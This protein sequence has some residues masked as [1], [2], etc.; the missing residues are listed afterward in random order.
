LN[1]S[2]WTFSF[3][4]F[5]VRTRSR[6]V[7]KHG[8]KLKLRPQP[9]QILEELLSRSGEL[10]T[11]EELREKLWSSETF[12][13]F[14]QS[15]NTSVKELRA[16]LGDSATEPRYVETVPR[17][18]Y[19]FIAAA[20][21]IEPA[22][23]NGN[24]LLSATSADSVLAEGRHIRRAIQ[25][26]VWLAVLVAATGIVV[27]A[28][29]TLRKDLGHSER[30]ASARSPDPKAV[31]AYLRG[32][33]LIDAHTT[34]D[35]GRGLAYFQ[36]AIR[37]DPEFAP[38]YAASA[39]MYWLLTSYG[40]EPI[41]AL[42]LMKSASDKALELD[43]NLADAHAVRGLVLV[44]LQNNWQAGETEFHRALEL[45][46]GESA[47]HAYYVTGFLLPLGRFDAAIAEM[48][49]TLELD[50]LSVAFNSDL[51]FVQYFARRYGEAEAQFHKALQME[52]SL[53]SANWALMQL[54][55]QQERWPE[56]FGQFQK[57]L[58][59]VENKP[60]S[61]GKSVRR[62]QFSRQEYW[63]NRI[64]MQEEIVKDLSDY[65]DLAVVYARSGQKKKAL[66]AL[67]MA[68]A[69]NDTYL[70]LINVEPAL[71]PLRDEPRFRELVKK[72][73]FPQD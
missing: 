2:N 26:W 33:A 1:A 63:E 44:Y 24:P 73:N 62:A 29:Y 9:F 66:D 64:K 65:V 8:I 35:I 17:L 70:K 31:D 13:D 23:A 4:S 54:Y 42:P 51:G 48:R 69:R 55:E 45:N 60:I 53:P 30:R 10:V 46:P 22:A 56:A 50:P 52:P 43:D 34:S 67:E 49:R 7:F 68:A 28:G 36:E 15:L 38:P 6:E 11:R 12:V 58:A 41:E 72:M 61:P 39:R 37:E 27:V 59:G 57:I 19:R 5:E 32:R 40:V 21:A 3:G 14:E 20:Q 25:A 16:V 18:G 47:T 71:D